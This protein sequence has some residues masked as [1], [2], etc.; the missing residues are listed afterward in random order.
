M[1]DSDLD[2]DMGL[3][4]SPRARRPHALR[5][6]L[7]GLLAVI[8]LAAGLAAAPVLAATSG[9]LHLRSGTVTVSLSPGVYAKLTRSTAGSYPDTRTLTPIHPA[10]SSTP[11]VFAFPLSHGRVDPIGLTGTAAS[12]GGIRF[13]SVSQNPSAGQS[14][15]VQFTLTG[16]AL[17]LSST[18][19]ELT[20][21]F[22]GTST[23][24]DIPIASLVTTSVDSRS[25]GRTVAL[26][27][28]GLKLLASG[29]QLFNQQAY[30]NQS[31][32][33]KVGQSIG[34]AT[35]TAVG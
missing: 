35:L 6:A 10:A 31:H 4:T 11:G 12:S 22:R 17:D 13:D 20:V 32:R 25:S 26:S 5:A 34:T 3:G 30:N 23:Y 14:S 29:A 21:T 15:T 16:F 8:A 27:G 2:A 1:F 28:F 24:H 9:P 18:P 7:C 19:A 33:F